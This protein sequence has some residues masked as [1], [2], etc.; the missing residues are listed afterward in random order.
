M[1]PSLP[2]DRSRM[3]AD[4]AVL[5]ALRA[6]D[7]RDRLVLWVRG[8]GFDTDVTE[9]GGE[10]VARVR[11]RRFAASFLDSGM[12]TADGGTV[13]RVVHQ[14]VGRRLVLMARERRNDLWFEALGAGVG[15][16]LPLPPE[17]AMVRA[18]L[19][20]VAGPDLLRG[21]RSNG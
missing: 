4:P 2:H 10:A 9:D 16:V 6:G 19:E 13:W 21:G 15:T 1:A 11:G 18:A 3:T 20:A 17:E 8:H 12:A 14:I 5:I 7:V